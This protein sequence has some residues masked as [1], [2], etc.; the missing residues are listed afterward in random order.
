MPQE[1]ELRASNTL[2][3]GSDLWADN[4]IQK[5]VRDDMDGRGS[6]TYC[7]LRESLGDFPGSNMRGHE[8]EQAITSGKG[9]CRFAA[10]R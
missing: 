1:F 4:D 3:H 8:R 2:Q 6:G 7:F 5:L 10:L 9:V